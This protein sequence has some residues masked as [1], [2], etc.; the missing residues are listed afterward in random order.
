MVM[1]SHHKNNSSICLSQLVE[2]SV[3]LLRIISGTS[4]TLYSKYKF[5]MTQFFISVETSKTVQHF[6]YIYFTYRNFIANILIKNI[7]S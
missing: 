3:V 4:L 2:I 1:L 7:S 6:I 5:E